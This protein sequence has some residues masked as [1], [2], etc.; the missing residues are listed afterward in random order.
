MAWKQ[1]GQPTV[2]KQ[3]D[4]WVVRVQGIDTGVRAA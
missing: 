3:R 2:Q 4:L 1:T